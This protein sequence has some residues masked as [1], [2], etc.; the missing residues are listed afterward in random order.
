MTRTTPINPLVI[1]PITPIIIIM[2]LTTDP[3]PEAESRMV[4]AQ[5]I[6]NTEVS[7][8]WCLTHTIF[9]FP[10]ISRGRP[11]TI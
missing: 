1:I 10:P 4:M 6:I 11:C 5:V 3:E 7:L 9:K 8:T 2:M